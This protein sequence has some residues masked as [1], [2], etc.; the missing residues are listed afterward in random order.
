[1]DARQQRIYDRLSRLVGPGAS[2]FFSDACQMMSAT[3][4]LE[5]TRHLVAHLLREVESALRDVLETLVKQ[6]GS[7]S[8][9]SGS[10]KDKHKKAIRRSLAALGIDDAAEVTAAWLK[11]AGQGND[12][13]LHAQAHRPNLDQPRPVDEEFLRYWDDLQELL[14]AV[15][16][17]LETKFMS[18]ID[19]INSLVDKDPP[20]NEDIKLLENHIP[21]VPVLRRYFFKHLKSPS[22]LEP[23]RHAGFFSHPP[24]AYRNS[25][26]QVVAYPIWPQSRYLIEIAPETPSNVRDTILGIPE[27]DNIY[28]TDDL[29][30][31]ALRMP[32][33]VASSLVEKI[34]AWHDKGYALPF[35][36]KAGKLLSYLAQNEQTEVAIQ[37][38]QSLLA[39]VE[40]KQ[41]YG[42]FDSRRPVARIRG[43][44]YEQILQDDM[45]FL[46]DAAGKDCLQLLCRLLND[47]INL[48]LSNPEDDDSSDLSYMWCKEVE[49]SCDSHYGEVDGILV[50][51][52]RDAALRLARSGKC[53][54]G[55][56]I[57]VLEAQRWHIFHRIALHVLRIAAPDR[58]DLVA[59]RLN[60]RE[61]F[62]DLPHQHEYA[63]L[64]KESFPKLD[65]EIQQEILG[66]IEQGPD[67]ERYRE[68]F[69]Q[70]FGSAASDQDITDHVAEWRRDR[71]HLLKEGLPAE[72]ATK[73]D[74]L[75]EQHGPAE[76]V[77][78]GRPS[79]STWMGPRSPFT[80]SELASMAPEEL[81]A[82]LQ[83]WESEGEL[84][85]PSPEGL[86]QEL[87]AAVSSDPAKYAAVASRFKVVSEPTYARALIEGLRQAAENGASLEWSPVLDLCRWILDQPR[88]ISGREVKHHQK[89]PDWSWTRKAIAHLMQTVFGRDLVGGELRSECWSIV[90]PLTRE[91]EPTVDQERRYNNAPSHI[92]INTA[93]GEAMIA[94][95]KYGLWVYRHLEKPDTPYWCSFEHMPEV[96]QVLD[97]HLDTANDPALSIRSVYGRY[98][99]QL[100]LLDR[101]WLI[102]KIPCI[103]PPDEELDEMREA[104]W[105]TYVV[106]NPPHNDVYKA[107]AEEYR[108]AIDRL[109]LHK[110]PQSHLGDPDNQL[111]E[112]LLVVYGR[113]LLG[114]DLGDD[115]LSQ[116]FGRASDDLC[117]YAVA[118]IG[119]SLAES[120]EEIDQEIIER[121]QSFWQSRVDAVRGSDCPSAHRGQIGAFG[122]WFISGRFPEDWA[123]ENI[124]NALKLV[125]AC[126]PVDDVA[127]KLAQL[128]NG[129]LGTAVECLGYIVD[130]LDDNERPHLW[131]KS[132]HELLQ[133]AAGHELTRAAA[134]AVV[135]KLAAKGFVEQFRDLG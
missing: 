49:G 17:K 45:P 92:A 121:F 6:T 78:I 133:K 44:N 85:A 71:L 16:E 4:A 15:L 70:F 118:H 24:T 101:Q 103:F 90:E 125:R 77:D 36:T 60:N 42:L 108:R 46:V 11:L 54:I 18:Y 99:P 28:I 27:I 57:A 120:E 98:L 9:A 95:I 51:A 55:E 117:Q 26:G 69:P 12:Y 33:D 134:L 48:S 8:D 62:D 75:V 35:P 110:L 73:Y 43:W 53:T 38:A 102:E 122:W 50:V 29:V 7:L 72:W 126:V 132:A 113:G 105:D 135:G 114:A 131:L 80:A 14:D 39:V 106:F 52:V 89:D 88:E 37:L 67:V 96:R 93:R 123:L 68:A 109:S 81:I 94:V 111:A 10:D 32:A 56:V 34:V 25:E 59:E 87:S 128:D 76:R 22:W 13:A 104:A 129:R 66:W 31:A 40:S 100:L 2:A 3:T 30:E 115:L 84:L 127:K 47:A 1:M 23:L 41:T 124:R 97:Y 79:F 116:Y 61:L 112:H 86:S 83:S 19:E 74:A 130:G 91:P 64:L 20:S 58:V 21:N 5:S 119:R 82:L 107:L 65:R 63:I